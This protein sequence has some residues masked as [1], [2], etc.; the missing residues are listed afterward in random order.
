MTRLA[1]VLLDDNPVEREQVRSALDV[2]AVPELPEDPSLYPRMIYEAGYFETVSFSR[3]DAARAEQYSANAARAALES[4]SCQIRAIHLLR[5]IRSDIRFRISG[6][7]EK[8]D[9]TIAFPQRDV[10]LDSLK[11]IE[12]RVVEP[13]T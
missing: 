13:T 2:V 6:L 7:F 8:N 5:V 12:V 9:I 10:H 1:L 11:P 4:E 3:E